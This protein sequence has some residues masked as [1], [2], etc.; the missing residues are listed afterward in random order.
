M[1]R[2]VRNVSITVFI[3]LGLLSCSGGGG[4]SGEEIGDD[5][6]VPDTWEDHTKFETIDGIDDSQED[7]GAGETACVQGKNPKGNG[8]NLPCTDG[9]HP[10]PDGSCYV[11]CPSFLSEDEEGRCT[12]PNCPDG[13]HPFSDDDPMCIFNCPEGFES[14]TGPEGDFCTLPCSTGF[15]RGED[16][17]CRLDCPVGMVP[18]DS[19]TECKLTDV[20]ESKL[21]PKDLWDESFTGPNPRYVDFHSTSP[22]PDGSITAPAPTIMQVVQQVEQEG[23]DRVTIFV[24]PGD[25]EEHVVFNEMKEVNLVGACAATTTIVGNGLGQRENQNKG[26]I[27]ANNVDVLL[28][29]GVSIISDRRGI[30]VD[31]SGQASTVE[32]D[33][34]RIDQAS[35]F[36]IYIS[37]GF[38]T[39]TVSKTSIQH[40]TGHGI[41]VTG[42]VPGPEQPNAS[43][44]TLAGNQ[45]TELDDCLNWDWC[46]A[47]PRNIGI[48]I[49]QI[50]S[51]VI[52]ENHISDIVHSSGVILSEVEKA[53]LTGNIIEGLNGDSGI[54]I[55]SSPN[56]SEVVIEGNRIAN[57]T[58]GEWALLPARSFHG[59][60]ISYGSNS[61]DLS[62]KGNL[63]HELQGFAFQLVDDLDIPG[64]GGTAKLVFEDNEI[65]GVS[66]GV[67]LDC[68]GVF[69]VAGNVFAH[70]TIAFQNGDTAD[71]KL[72]GNV[73][74]DGL[75][76]DNGLP[77]GTVKKYIGLSWSQIEIWNSNNDGNFEFIGNHVV[78][79]P[80][81]HPQDSRYGAVLLMETGPVLVKGNLFEENLANNALFS[82]DS[83]G[84]EISGNLFI[85]LDDGDS[86]PPGKR[87][88]V[89][90]NQ[91]DASL[92]SK[93]IFDANVF[94]DFMKPFFDATLS[95]YYEHEDVSFQFTGNRFRKAGWLY[96][97]NY[98][99][100]SASTLD[101]LGNDLTDSSIVITSM[102]ALGFMDNR[103]HNF[104]GILLNQE[105]ETTAQFENNL[106]QSGMLQLIGPS[107]TTK[108]KNNGFSDSIGAGLVVASSSGTVDVEHNLFS[109]TGPLSWE[110]AGTVGDALEITGTSED[111]CSGVSVTNNRI[112]DSS[113]Y[114]I[115]VS[116][117]S[118]HVEG[119]M[120][121]ENGEDCG[122]TCDLAIQLE[123]GSGAVSGNDVDFAT[124]PA[125]PAGVLT[126]DHLQ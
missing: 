108:F 86:D 72:S 112:M 107:G 28:V 29:S 33:Q 121:V 8:C 88:A 81:L 50:S 61:I 79:Q 1:Y 38:D 74:R 75:L 102:Q 41:L 82:L 100:A 42:T 97:A 6:I 27:T 19:S 13:W 16:G 126:V 39:V 87:S 76:D 22:V 43:T 70:S 9:W 90:V 113:R 59:I 4:D 24:A 34:T 54:L 10:G 111:P 103:L 124:K 3:C 115:I 53:K 32:I 36:G 98:N 23:L 14:L 95:L 26:A 12:V 45:I 78:G 101:F 91:T 35:D 80:A 69:S 52:Q 99:D 122:G 83:A 119:N 49:D 17:Q 117:A 62:I 60:D 120:Y 40:S 73:F 51:V 55:G 118:A 114:G 37:G 105:V 25:Y 123:P 93:I 20:G 47:G 110:G 85:G 89:W 5:I 104:Y 96:F 15:S 46:P 109:T 57:G 21:C 7:L 65:D 64:M 68:L 77:D 58:A 11:D 67:R 56:L 30:H 94:Q 66:C 44:V 2:S 31:H 18:A 63:L 106:F 116:G 92:D 125:D 71:L 48:Q 84:L